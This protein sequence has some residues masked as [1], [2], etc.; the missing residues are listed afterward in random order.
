MPNPPGEIYWSPRAKR[1]YQQGR[2]G[3]V[4]NEK[5]L[6]TL[7]YDSQ[8]GQWRDQRGRFVPDTVLAPV[9][10]RV[11]RFT[12]RD[13]Q[14][15]PFISTEFHDRLT[16][17]QQVTRQAL[18]G[19]QQVVVRT[20]VKGPDGRLHITYTTSKLGERIN[21]NAL[22]DKANRHASANLRSKGMDISTPAV[23]GATVSRSY[24]KRTV[25][26]RR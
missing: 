14:N 3:A 11:H 18:K 21:I 16:S 9:V 6:P 5:G 2:R 13:E 15:R 24:H 8:R 1:F 25:N 4:S 23:E 17:R 19:N 10:K 12:A 22:D 7:R 20:V 26:V